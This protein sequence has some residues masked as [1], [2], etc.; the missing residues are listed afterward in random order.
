MSTKRYELN[1]NLAAPFARSNKFSFKVR[2]SRKMNGGT[3][4]ISYQ[5]CPVIT[6]PINGIIQT[7]NEIAQV[8]IEAFCVPT[9]TYRNGENRLQGNF[10][11]EVTEETEDFDLD[12]DPI[13]D[14]VE[15]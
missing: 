8:Y 15:L 10:F 4:N 6:I 12:L 7:S 14:S 3:V 11:S 1:Q 5:K 9:N 2:F 13:F